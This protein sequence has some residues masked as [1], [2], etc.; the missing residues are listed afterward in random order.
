M[1][2]YSSKIPSFFV[3]LK[4]HLLFLLF[5]NLIQLDIQ[6]HYKSLF[7]FEPVY[8]FLKIFNVRVL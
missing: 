2:V 3:V 5:V 7:A 8:V 4:S 1:F 6:K